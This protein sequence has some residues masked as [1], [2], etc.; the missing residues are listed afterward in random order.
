MKQEK[1]ITFYKLSVAG[2]LVNLKQLWTGLITN[3]SFILF[4][5]G[6]IAFVVAASLINFIV[7]WVVA[8]I[9]LIV[10]AYVIS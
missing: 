3:L 7:G 1:S 6:L 10:L 8:G 5:F 2:R 4:L 9:A